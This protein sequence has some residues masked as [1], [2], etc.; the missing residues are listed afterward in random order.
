MN[1]GP[2]RFD[3]VAYMRR[4]RDRLSEQIAG[5]PYADLAGWL[6]THRYTDPRLERLAM[7]AAQQAGAAGGTGILPVF[8][9]QHWRDASATQGVDR[10]ASAH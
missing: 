9:A 1:N 7:R 5:M 3:C 6:R 2:E 4:V 10:G 8:R